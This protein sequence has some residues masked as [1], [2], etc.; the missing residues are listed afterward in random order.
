M[1]WPR[2]LISAQRLD[3]LFATPATGTLAR[4]VYDH[5]PRTSHLTD[6]AALLATFILGAPA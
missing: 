5:T 6:H 4:C 2:P 3:H 1:A